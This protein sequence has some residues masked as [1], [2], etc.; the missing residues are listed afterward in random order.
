MVAL[1]ETSGVT[2]VVRMHHLET[3][4]VWQSIK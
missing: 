2:D 1:D 3:M 4:N